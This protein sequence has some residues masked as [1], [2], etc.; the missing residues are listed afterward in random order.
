MI[1]YLV[2]LLVLG[3]SN[4]SAN[5][6]VPTSRNV[7]SSDRGPEASRKSDHGSEIISHATGSG[8]FAELVLPYA[9]TEAERPSKDEIFTWHPS[10]GC[11]RMVPSRITL[12]S[13]SPFTGCP[14]RWPL[15]A[16]LLPVNRAV[17]VEG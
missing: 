8:S 16:R 3:I 10:R 15:K 17:M 6:W 4:V 2:F 13:E 5:I 9:T 12:R 1:S 14:K 7:L 11:S